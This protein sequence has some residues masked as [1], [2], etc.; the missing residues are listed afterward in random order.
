MASAWRDAPRFF[1]RGSSLDVE[2]QLCVFSSV[3][4]Q[5]SIGHR[6]APEGRR[7][8]DGMGV[9][10]RY[11]YDALQPCAQGSG[12][13]AACT[14]QYSIA[15]LTIWRSAHMFAVLCACL[16]DPVC[17][18]PAESRS[19]MG[20]DH[21]EAPAIESLAGAAVWVRAKCRE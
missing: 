16:V 17:S 10:R 19:I 7:C 3:T 13:W 5:V 21:C 4:R 1:F 8:A 6:Y 15:V 9:R 11:E 20:L 12:L 18:Q 14:L 2:L